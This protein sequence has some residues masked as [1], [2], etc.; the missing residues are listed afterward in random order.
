MFDPRII[1]CQQD[2]QSASLT[3]ST[4]KRKPPTRQKTPKVESPILAKKRGLNKT[5]FLKGFLAA[6]RFKGGKLKSDSCNV[7]LIPLVFGRSRFFRVSGQKNVAASD[8]C[9]LVDLLS[10]FFH[11][12]DGISFLMMQCL[13]ICMRVFFSQFTVS[14]VRRSWAVLIYLFVPAGPSLQ[15]RHAGGM[16]RTSAF[17]FQVT[18]H[19]HLGK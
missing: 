17:H 13:I 16:A 15:F 6:T 4:P 11:V 9:Q 3:V 2:F 19:F 10:D 18:S 14:H 8:R 1:Q 5:G 12:S 7:R